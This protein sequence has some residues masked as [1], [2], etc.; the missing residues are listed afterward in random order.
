MDM[1]ELRLSPEGDLERFRYDIARGINTNLF[2]EY[3]GI[4]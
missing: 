2:Q 4:F 3:S 1:K